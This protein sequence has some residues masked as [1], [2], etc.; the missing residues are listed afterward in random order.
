MPTQWDP[1]DPLA[2]EAVAGLVADTMPEQCLE[3]GGFKADETTPGW[4]F[5]ERE[6]CECNDDDTN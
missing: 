2:A 1:R 6:I 5:K 4:V 3:C